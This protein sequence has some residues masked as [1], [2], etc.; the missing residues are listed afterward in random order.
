MPPARPRHTTASTRS[1]ATAPRKPARA[2]AETG[3]VDYVVAV[4]DP[5]G[6]LPQW[7][8]VDGGFYYATADGKVHMLVGGAQ[9]APAK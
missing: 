2:A 3:R 9:D 7:Q 8:A 1:A 5:A 4:N 6:V